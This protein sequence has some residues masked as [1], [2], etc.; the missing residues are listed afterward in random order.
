[1]QNKPVN[2]I[3]HKAAQIS[4]SYLLNMFLVLL[5]IDFIKVYISLFIILVDGVQHMTSHYLT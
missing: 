1:M 4:V 2:I 3:V 5:K